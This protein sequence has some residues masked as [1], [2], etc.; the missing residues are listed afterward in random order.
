[1]ILV[2]FTPAYILDIGQACPRRLLFMSSV[3][4]VSVMPSRKACR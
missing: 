2:I 3:K 1:M 4:L